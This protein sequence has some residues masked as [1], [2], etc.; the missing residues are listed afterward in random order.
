MPQGSAKVCMTCGP[1][2][3][4]SKDCVLLRSHK[5]WG[6]NKIQDRWEKGLGI[7]DAQNHPDMPVF[8]VKPE[9]GGPTKVVHRDQMK[10]C[11]FETPVARNTPY[12]HR[13]ILH[14]SES[15][16]SDIVYAPRIFPQTSPAHNTYSHSSSQDDT[17][18]TDGEEAKSRQREL[19]VG[20]I[21]WG[22]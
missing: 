20:Q 11:V 16:A 10:L 19:G 13:P 9:A 21:F 1:R 6:R 3:P 5:P 22:E 17:S 12:E 2:V 15:D 8:T 7:V 14:A 18:D 4:S